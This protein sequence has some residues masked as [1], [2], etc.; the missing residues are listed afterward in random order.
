MKKVVQIVLAVLIL[1]MAYVVYQQIMTPLRFQKQVKLRE[2]AVIERIKDIRSAERGYKQV[3]NKYTGS[4]DSLIN[5]VL[6]DS[7]V[8]EKATGSADDSVAVAQGLVKVERFKIAAKDTVFGNRVL[9]TEDIQK[10][11]LIPYANGVEYNLRATIL[12]IESSR[13]KVPVFECT[14]PYKDFLYD[15]DEQELINLIDEQKTV[16]NKYPGIKVGS[17]ERTTNDAGNWE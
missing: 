10:L 12:T 7:L 14:A 2:T 17:I 6:T 15:L 4:F 11:R 1:V 13:L 16:Y 3:Y 5:F 9:S 8:F